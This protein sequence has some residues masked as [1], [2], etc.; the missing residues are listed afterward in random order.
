M[1]NSFQEIW[2]QEW[3]IFSIF[4]A[5]KVWGTVNVFTPAFHSVQGAGCLPI[6]GVYV[7]YCLLGGVPTKGVW[8]RGCVVKGGVGKGRGV[9]TG[10]VKA[11]MVKDLCG[12]VSWIVVDTPSPTELNIS[13]GRNKHLLETKAEPQYWLLVVAIEAGGTHSTGIPACFTYIKSS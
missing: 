10:F 6:R 2:K 4:T 1:F 7:Y 12:V 3:L 8:W 11:G 13:L 9:V 5:L